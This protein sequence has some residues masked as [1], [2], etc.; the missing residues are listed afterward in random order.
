[1]NDRNSA[2][3][4][5]GHGGSTLL[6][7]IAFGVLGLALA[8]VAFFFL[9]IALMA[10]AV[11]ALVLAVRWWWAMRRVRAAR[12]AAGPLEGEYTVVRDP[13]ERLR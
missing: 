1:M 6:A 11:L 12:T 10:G 4:L 8:A 7:R 2:F 13:G 9:T 3:L 5:T